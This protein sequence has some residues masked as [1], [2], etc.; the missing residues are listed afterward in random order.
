[1]CPR[2]SKLPVL[3]RVGLIFIFLFMTFE[4]RPILGQALFLMP[5]LNHVRFSIGPNV[6]YGWDRY[7]SH[8]AFVGLDTTI[9]YGL[10]WWTVG[11]RSLLQRGKQ[12]IAFIPY[13]ETGIWY[14]VNLGVGYD[15]VWTMD[16]GMDN[17]FHV[18]A[19]LPFPF[20]GDPVR[21]FGGL[22]EPYCRVMFLW[23]ARHSLLV[24]E[25]GILIKLFYVPTDEK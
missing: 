20:A 6:A 12:E 8:G 1:M 18:F 4:T 16:L 10:F 7:G 5:D 24:P 22:I 17:G 21:G 9:S 25:A 15:F 14:F 3:F 13:V 11:F 19:G 23:G 2:W